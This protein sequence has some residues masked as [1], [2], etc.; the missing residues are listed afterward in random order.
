M[1]NSFT[2]IIMDLIGVAFAVFIFNSVVYFLFGFDMV[3]FIVT[4]VKTRILGSRK[5]GRRDENS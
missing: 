1:L 5:S 2:N 3:C 4:F